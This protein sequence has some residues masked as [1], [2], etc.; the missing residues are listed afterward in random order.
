ML[1]RAKWPKHTF[2]A[3]KIIEC[4]FIKMEKFTITTF[5]YNWTLKDFKHPGGQS[6]PG[7]CCEI[8]LW[9]SGIVEGA[10]ESPPTSWKLIWQY[11]VKILKHPINSYKNKLI[12]ILQGLLTHLRW[13]IKWNWKWFD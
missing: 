6:L 3:L 11:V 9:N 1:H 13:M 5:L 4:T 8:P 7:L 12:D 10:R 2:K